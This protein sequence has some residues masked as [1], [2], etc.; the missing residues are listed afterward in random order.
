MKPILLLDESL[1][2]EIYYSCEDADLEDNICLKVIESCEEEE[3]IFRHDE[4]YLYLTLAQAQALASALLKA[5]EK[6]E[7]GK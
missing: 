6:S 3:K 7:K 2:V 5:I 4:S 1:Q